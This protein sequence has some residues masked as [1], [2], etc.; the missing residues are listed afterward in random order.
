MTIR[1]GTVLDQ[2]SVFDYKGSFDSTTSP[3]I[4]PQWVGEHA[5]RLH[6]YSLLHAYVS[7]ASRFW[8]EDAA[9]ESKRR[10]YGDPFILTETALVSLIGDRQRVV[11]EG[12]VASTVEGEVDTTTAPAVATQE[13]IEQWIE[14]EK[15]YMKM[16]ESERQSIKYGDSVYVLAPD[17]AKGRPRLHVYDPGFYFPVFDPLN[18]EGSE[19][20]PSKVH[21]AWE[22]QMMVD[23]KEV[24]FV[25]RI[26]WELKTVAPYRPDYSDADVTMNCEYTDAYWRI[27]QVGKDMT[28]AWGS[29]HAYVTEPMMMNIDFIPVVHIPNGVA[30]QNHFGTS[31]LGPVMQILDDIQATDT[32]LQA[33]AAT[34]GT[35]PIAITGRSSS[36]DITSYGPGAVF[37]CGDGQAT[38]LDTSKSLTALLELKDALL[39]RLSVNS[40]TPEAL[41]GRVKPNEVPSG[42]SMTL[43]FAPHTGM[44][45]EMRLVR[46]EK[47]PVLFKFVLRLMGIKDPPKVNLVMG[48]FLP[49]DKQE[50]VSEIVQLMSAQAISLE[51]AV[52]M[53]IES[54]FP[55]EDMVLEIERIQAR[56][57]TTATSLMTLTGDPNTGLKF[58]GRPT[59]NFSDNPTD[60]IGP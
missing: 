47:Y 32:D 28:V 58:M 10:E 40:R 36:N 52:Q 39:E 27:D 13:L 59:V 43:S 4:L 21:I 33:A 44:I 41:L 45:K 37:Y 12:A 49:A 17:A 48:S 31:V 14:D 18:R 1:S 54:G 25:R 19:D 20:F 15:F 16:V 56:D 29:Q 8:L 57:V 51:T 42:I 34:T 11:V 26:T 46:K 9:N 22:F 30:L 6:A 24:D 2:Y 5:R 55:I 23:G 38:V 3:D 60:G 50:A 7:N 35:P 53:L